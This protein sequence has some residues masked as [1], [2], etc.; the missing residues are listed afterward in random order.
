MANLV[1][2]QGM[3]HRD[4]KRFEPDVFLGYTPPRSSAVD[5]T[6]CPYSAR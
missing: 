4:D 3:T 2:G 5:D 6:R 1:D